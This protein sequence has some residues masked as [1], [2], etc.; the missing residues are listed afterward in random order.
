[1]ITTQEEL[2]A[3]VAAHPDAWHQ[4]GDTGSEWLVICA[5]SR[6]D[7]RRWSLV[8][9]HDGS[10]VIAHAGS[11][12]VAHAGSH[13]TAL[14]YSHVTAH[15]GAS[16]VEIIE[17]EDFECFCSRPPVTDYAHY[18]CGAC[19]ELFCEFHAIQHLQA[20]GEE[21]QFDG[22]PSLAYLLDRAFEEL[23]P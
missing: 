6:V 10:R 18:R 5:G 21:H 4:V 23:E 17:E 11:W 12:V 8:H 22:C 9:A 7:A 1:M 13:V 15:D 16:V 20:W 3:A 19:G 2:D 14:K